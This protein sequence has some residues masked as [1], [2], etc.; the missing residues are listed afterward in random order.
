[1]PTD[2]RLRVHPKERLAAP[3]SRIALNDAAARLRAEAHPPV[4]GHRQLALIKHGP[5][6]VILFA[7]EQ[8]GALKEHQAD[9]EVVI[10]VLKGRLTV[11]TDGESFVLTAGTLVALAPGQRHA[12]HAHEAS[13]MLLTVARRPAGT[14]TGM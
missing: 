9:G 12:V 8:G 5:L 14:T 2:D 7:F 1:M 4:A 13:D 11:D 10:Q 6:A 3:A